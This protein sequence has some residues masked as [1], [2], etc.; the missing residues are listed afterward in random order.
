MNPARQF[1]RGLFALW[2]LTP[3]IAGTRFMPVPENFWRPVAQED[4][5]NDHSWLTCRS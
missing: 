4:T 2:L 1:F 5:D 3:A